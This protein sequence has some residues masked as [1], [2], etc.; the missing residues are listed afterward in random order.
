MERS[1]GRSSGTLRGLLAVEWAVPLP[2]PGRY[3]A[4]HL[5]VAATSHVAHGFVVRIVLVRPILR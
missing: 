5:E 1:A 3:A 2:R 4:V